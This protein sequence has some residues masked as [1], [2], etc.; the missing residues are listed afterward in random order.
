V[1][2]VTD[3]PYGTEY[4]AAWRHRRYPKQRTAVGRVMHDDRVDW[5][6][7]YQLFHG[8]VA[9]VWH[10]GLFATEVAVSLQAAGFA[11]RSQIIW[12]KQVFVLSRG[13]YHWQHEPCWY[14]VRRGG[15][16][17]WQGDRTQST[18]WS[19]P[20]LNPMG[21]DRE[22]ANAVTG[23][24]TQKPVRLFER[25]ILNHTQP[26]ESV[27]D[28]FSGSGSSVIAADKTGRA[29]LAIDIDPVYV[30]ATIDRWERYRGEKA[31]RVMRAGGAS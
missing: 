8:D 16:S 3:P 9:Y 25:A 13:D 7:A 15:T 1:V 23:H 10:A 29:C 18:L 4:D 17:H 22:G 11:L 2:M 6:A 26:G 31:V 30:Q 24:S 19:V 5:S 28:P 20:N 14:A 12:A 27:Y 21:G